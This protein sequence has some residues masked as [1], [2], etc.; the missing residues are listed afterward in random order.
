MC[1]NSLFASDTQVFF[2]AT[3]MGIAGVYTK[4]AD[5]GNPIDI[6]VILNEEQNLIEYSTDQE[7]E[8]IV[9]LNASDVPYPDRGDKLV[10]SGINWSF[11][12]I[13]R[14]DEYVKQCLFY[15]DVR[16]KTR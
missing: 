12:R 7:A 5:S 10:V 15:R 16:T 8:A 4:H 3:E 2:N 6:V 13:I 14:G 1:A 9:S 11:R